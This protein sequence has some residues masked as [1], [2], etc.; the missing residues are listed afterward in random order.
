MRKTLFYFG[1]IILFFTS[2]TDDR[3]IPEQKIIVDP[4]SQLIF[5]WNFNS[6]VGTATTIAPDFESSTA[7]AS[8]EYNGTG[9]GYMDADTGG[10]TINAQ[11]NDLGENLL[12]VRNPS[13]TRSLILNVPTTGYKSV[14]VQFA[15]ARSPNTGA[16]IQNYS[17]TIDGINYIQTG[18]TKITQNTT[19]DLPDLIALDF[20]NI[21][22]VN[23]NPNFKVKIDFD[24][25][26]ISG[27]SG[28]NRF[29]NVT[30]EGAPN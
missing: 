4:N 17:Y 10:Y 2:C 22:A 19:A 29:D 7:T 30:L 24:G 1:F 16:T 26:T 15:T 6:L 12:K 5:Y 14:I 20:S 27:T 23:N 25:D 13:D 21:A 11:N 8:I 18:L 28:N 9:A 3:T